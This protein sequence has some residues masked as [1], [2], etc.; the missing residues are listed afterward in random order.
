MEDHPQDRCRRCSEERQAAA[1]A[2]EEHKPAAEVLA[3]DNSAAPAAGNS[4]VARMQAAGNLPAVRCSQ[5]FCP[6]VAEC[7]Q[8]CL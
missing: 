1:P 8:R 3:A 6:G 7:L 5:V 4:A 2:A